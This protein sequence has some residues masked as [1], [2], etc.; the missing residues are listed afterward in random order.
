MAHTAHE[1]TRGDIELLSLLCEE[2]AESTQA[3]CK[4][5]RH[6]RM[7]SW[8]DREYDNVRDLEKELGHVKA[9]ID[10]LDGRSIINGINVILAR[11]RKLKTIGEFLHFQ[12]SI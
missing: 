10:L 1:L 3:A 7:G 2:L 4:I 9:A 8:N 11:D 6:G 12:G 5:L